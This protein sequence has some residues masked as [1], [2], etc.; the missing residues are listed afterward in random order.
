MTGEWALSTYS[1]LFEG[2]GV[3]RLLSPFL[4]PLSLQV[5]ADLSSI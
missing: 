1:P 3:D 2:V 5:L 4:L